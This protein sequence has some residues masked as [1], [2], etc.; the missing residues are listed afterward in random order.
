VVGNREDSLF[1][2]LARRVDEGQWEEGT[3]E[4]EYLLDLRSTASDPSARLVLY[5][6]KGGN[7]AAILSDNVVPQ[8]RRGPDSLDHLFVVY[9]AD[10]GRIISGYQVSGL[11][12]VNVS[13]DPLWLR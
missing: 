13:G 4:E 1:Y 10:R 9:S 6:L 12:Q 3:M 11:E 8:D 5:T 7:V 2:H